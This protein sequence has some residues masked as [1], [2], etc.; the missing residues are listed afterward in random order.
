MVVLSAK[1][2]YTPL[3]K[4][5]LFI[6]SSKQ[7]KK[8]LRDVAFTLPT[9]FSDDGDTVDHRALESNVSH[10]ISAGGSLFVPCGNTGEYYSLSDQERIDVTETTVETVEDEHTVLAGAGGSTKDVISLAERYAAV[11]ADATM[12]MPPSHAYLHEV[13]IR[14]YYEAIADASPLPLV[15]YK[16]SHTISDDALGEVVEHENV[17]GVKYAVN[18]IDAFAKVAQVDADVV[19]INGIAERYAPAFALE[20]A[21]GF[22]TGIGNFAPE[23]ALDLWRA[24]DEREWDRARK[25]RDQF[26]SLEELREEGG[27][28]NDISAANNVPVIKHCMELA[29]LEGGPVREPIVD[30]SDEDRQR[31]REYYE[32]LAKRTVEQ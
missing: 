30:L 12:V 32:P 14:E 28:N 11:G 21:E 6:M 2:F 19:W 22:S 29:G 4:S 23:L 24:L 9:P 18:D 1:R 13:G 15:L 25:I 31:A 26:Q 7:V 3:M 10:L 8:S 17:I 27:S 20:G 5:S 16:R